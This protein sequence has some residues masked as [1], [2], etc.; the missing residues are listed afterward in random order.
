MEL[1][2]SHTGKQKE[3]CVLGVLGPLLLPGYG[4]ETQ[5]GEKGAMLK[6]ILGS[7]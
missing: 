1:W 4:I 2:F 3:A 6:Y 5:N 7:N